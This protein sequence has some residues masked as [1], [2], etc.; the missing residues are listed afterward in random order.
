MEIQSTTL[1]NMRFMQRLLNNQ[2]SKQ[3]AVVAGVNTDYLMLPAHSSLGMVTSCYRFMPSPGCVSPDIYATN[4][5]GQEMVLR[6]FE[7]GFTQ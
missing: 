3:L 6:I 1:D 4:L 5:P 7:G 2:Q